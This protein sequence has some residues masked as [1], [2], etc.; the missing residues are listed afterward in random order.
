MAFLHRQND[1]YL[2]T[3]LA[4]FNAA[5]SG[6]AGFVE[7]FDGV[8]DGVDGEALVA[9]E[10][11]NGRL[12]PGF[13]GLREEVF[14]EKLKLPD[15]QVLFGGGL[16]GAELKDFVVQFQKSPCVA[17]AESEAPEIFAHGRGELQQP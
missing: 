4:L 13:R 6:D 10:A 1:R 5:G 11:C 15:G 9:V 3:V 17:L 8:E 2:N 7:G 16:C 14:D 12:A